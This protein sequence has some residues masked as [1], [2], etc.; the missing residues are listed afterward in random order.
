MRSGIGRQSNFTE[1]LSVTPEYLVQIDL[2]DESKVPPASKDIGLLLRQAMDKIAFL[3]FGLLVDKWR[4]GVFSGEIA[5]A[6]YTR[7]FPLYFCAAG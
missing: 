1:A 3:P 2:L 4:W 6:Q 5:P 7:S